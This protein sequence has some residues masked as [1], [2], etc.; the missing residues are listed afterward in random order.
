MFG[1]I[2]RLIR[3]PGCLDN[4]T[5][6]MIHFFFKGL[7]SFVKDDPGFFQ[8]QYLDLQPREKD[9]FHKWLAEQTE[10]KSITLSK[11]Y[12]IDQLIKIKK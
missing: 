10:N 9:K 12:K 4:K 7:V 2:R 8:E 1:L 3:K 5:P 6:E 11:V